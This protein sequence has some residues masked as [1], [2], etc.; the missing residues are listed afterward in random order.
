MSLPLLQLGDSALPI[1]GFS[2]SWGLEAA[3]ERG[4]VSSPSALEEWTRRW[5]RHSLAPTEGVVLVAA[6]H[7]M[8]G[9]RRGLSPP[10]T[11]SNC[12]FSEGIDPSAR[13]TILR[14][15]RYLDVGLLPPTLRQA[16]RDMGDQLRRLAEPWPWATGAIPHLTGGPW[17]HAVVFGVLAGCATD[18]AAQ[19][20]SVYL[21]QAALGMIGAGVRAIPIGHTHGQLILARLHDDLAELAKALQDSRLESAGSVCP[22]YEEL[23]HA[24]QRLYTRLFRS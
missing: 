10:E 15:N 4:L 24:Q 3:I 14:A 20:V 11:G 19:A 12:T 13:Q 17:H 5:L 18:D 2:H 8:Q 23:C 21:H 9:E 7:A 16:S 1:G 22:A 6:F